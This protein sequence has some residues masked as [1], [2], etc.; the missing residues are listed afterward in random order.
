MV[1]K[2][3]EAMV[4]FFRDCGFD[5]RLTERSDGESTIRLGLSGPQPQEPDS[6][7]DTFLEILYESSDDIILVDIFHEL[8]SRFVEALDAELITDIVNDLH[9]Y[10]VD[11]LLGGR[12]GPDFPISLRGLR[13]TVDEGFSANDLSVRHGSVF[14]R[15]DLGSQPRRHESFQGLRDEICEVIAVLWS[16]VEDVTTSPDKAYYFKNPEYPWREDPDVSLDEIFVEVWRFVFRNYYDRERRKTLMRGDG[17][18]DLPENSYGMS[19]GELAK[20]L[21]VIPAEIIRVIAG[22]GKLKTPESA[23]ST[24]E[25]ELI[26]DEL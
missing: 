26:C 9:Y 19:V 15:R 1:A 4:W 3:A 11:T 12:E 10:L 5:A 2:T 21:G 6:S 22:L 13:R 16:W 24:E 17:P 14:E 7:V 20:V 18:E 25:V 8:P 23:L